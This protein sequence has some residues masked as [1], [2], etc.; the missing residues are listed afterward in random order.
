MIYYRRKVLS[1]VTLFG[2]TTRIWRYE[3]MVGKANCVF[4]EEH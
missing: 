3:R 4:G 2:K 1:G